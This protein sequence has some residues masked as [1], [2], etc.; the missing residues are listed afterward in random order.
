MNLR[1]VDGSA[2][3]DGQCVLVD[4]SIVTFSVSIRSI[5]N[6]GPDDIRDQLQKKWEV[7][8]IKETAAEVFVR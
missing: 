3:E 5:N 2:V 8:D 1:N 7:T 6:V 4:H